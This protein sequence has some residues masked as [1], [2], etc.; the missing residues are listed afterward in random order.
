MIIFVQVL[1]K[2]RVYYENKT[3]LQNLLLLPFPALF[4]HVL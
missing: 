2:K 1:P 4:C 3:I